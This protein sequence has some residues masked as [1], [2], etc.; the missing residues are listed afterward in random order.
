MPRMPPSFRMSMPAVSEDDDA[1]PPERSMGN[2]FD[3]RKKRAVS[4]PLTP[5]P[6][7][8][9]DFARKTTGLG[10][11]IGRKIESEKDRWLLTITAGPDEGMLS[12]PFTHGRKR[13]LRIGPTM[14]LF[15][16]Q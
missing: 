12:R 1:A 11:T 9:S 4:L 14:I 7:K 15:I 16:T 6:V 5:L 10:T 13:R 3:N 2:W 8:Y